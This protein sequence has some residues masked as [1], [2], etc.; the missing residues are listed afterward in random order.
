M[1]EFKLLTL[2]VFLVLAQSGASAHAATVHLV[3]GEVVEPDNLN[4]GDSLRAGDKV[5]TGADGVVM[6]EYRWRSDVPGYDCQHLEIFGYGAS[7]TVTAI[8]SPGQC[9]TRVASVPD[10]GTFS[11]SATRY[12]D[13]SYDDPNPPAKVTNS[14][15][16]SRD[17]DRW[18]RNAQR[19][20]TGKVEYIS[21]REIEVKGA[22]AGSSK[23]FSLTASALAGHADRNSLV[24]KDVRLTYRASGYRPEAFHIEVLSSGAVAQPFV[25]VPLEP[26]VFEPG[27]TT[28]A[29]ETK[30]APP[31]PAPTTQT[32]RCEVDLHQGDVGTIEL[33]RSDEKVRGAMYIEGFNDK[34]AIS[35]TW[36]GDK[37]EF[38]RELSPSSGQP[39]TG[40]ATRTSTNVVAMA[41][42]FAN[43]YSGVWSA[44][45]KLVVATDSAETPP[46]G[47]EGQYQLIL[48]GYE[49][50]KIAAIKSVREVSGMGLRESKEA[51]EEP[52]STLLSN[53]SEEEARR[54]AEKLDAAGV[55]VR[56]ERP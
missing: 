3:S 7:Y 16:Q 47:G 26:P 50:D 18:I 42:R 30:P 22:R 48:T 6:I 55:K 28:E 15:A 29:P 2:L 21:N 25:V 40:T 8:E 12:G 37:I 41:G 4:E 52:P 54:L 36:K 27:G 13:A 9:V 39:F 45:C 46:A 17:L 38:W 35:G 31:S 14:R 44:D 11:N 20:Y 34:Y 33:M 5:R 19:A 32:W 51:V 24:G 10:S 56:I 23:T 49:G 43:Q 53:L 1:S